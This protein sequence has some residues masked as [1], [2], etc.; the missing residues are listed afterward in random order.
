MFDNSFLSEEEETKAFQNFFKKNMEKDYSSFYND[1]EQLNEDERLYFIIKPEPEKTEIPKQRNIKEITTATSNPKNKESPPEQQLNNL[2]NSELNELIPTLPKKK[3]G[4]KKRGDRSER[5][6]T[7]SRDDNKMRKIKV[8]IISFILNLLNNLISKNHQK[9]LKIDKDIGENL[10]KDFNMKL[11]EM[12]IRDIFTEFSI[13]RRYLTLREG[14]NLN[15]VLI[16]QIYSRNDTKLIEILESKYVDLLQILRK[17]YLDQFRRDLLKKEVKCGEE[18][19]KAEKYVGEL[20]TLLC[21]Y[22]DWFKK[23]S[24][25]CR[26]V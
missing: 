13:N 25:R 15:L 6:H 4:R 14:A 23:K 10:K 8:Y 16:N 5:T 18:K 3:L 17:D 1:D 19:E 26:Q 11:M 7:K 22:E 12:K 20:V 9:F 24:G 2:E 21:G